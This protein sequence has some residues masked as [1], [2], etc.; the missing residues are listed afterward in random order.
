MTIT[1]PGTRDAET[2]DRAL[3][4]A[5]LRWLADHLEDDKDGPV[6]VVHANYRIPAG[7]RE[8]R[9]ARLNEIARHLGTTAAPDDMGTL[10]ARR[11]FGPVTAE[12]HVSHPDRSTSAYLARAAARNAAGKAAA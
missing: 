1:E 6:P 3:T 2:L 11:D 7:T 12:A 8:Q 4:V 10:I 9:T 5:G